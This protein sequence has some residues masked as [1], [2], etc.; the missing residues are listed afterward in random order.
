V[1]PLPITFFRRPADLVARELLGAT[2]VSTIAGLR[3]SGIIVETEAY[4]GYDDPASHGYRGRRHA[5]NLNLY[6]DAGTWYVYRSYGIHWCANLVCGLPAAGSAV[7]L[8]GVMPLEGAEA[9][10]ERRNGAGARRLADGPGKLCQALGI[11]RE[12]DGKVMRRS[13]VL[14]GRIRPTSGIVVT[15]RIGIS[16]AVDWPLRFVLPSLSA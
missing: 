2:I 5:G 9:M 13:D 16:K 11:T 12:L 6:A 7:L 8:R 3:A 10:R 4:L 15:P 14:V 1:R